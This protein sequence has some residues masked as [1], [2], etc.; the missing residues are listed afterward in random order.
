VDLRKF[1][2]LATAKSRLSGGGI[3]LFCYRGI[4]TTALIERDYFARV[5]TRKNDNLSEKYF[6][7]YCFYNVF[8]LIHQK[9][10]MDDH[11]V[12]FANYGILFLQ[13]VYTSD[14]CIRELG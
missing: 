7:F 1:P 13:Q 12:I 11:P 3:V 10:P 4:F 14:A 5:Y 6:L 9:D 8:Y 2:T